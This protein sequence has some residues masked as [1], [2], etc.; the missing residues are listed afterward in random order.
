MGGKGTNA[1]ITQKVVV[2]QSHDMGEEEENESY[3]YLY[4]Q[5]IAEGE[6]L[7]EGAAGAAPNG[8]MGELDDGNGT[9]GMQQDTHQAGA[10]SGIGAL[11]N[12]DV[13]TGT[14]GA[15]THHGKP[16]YQKIPPEKY[17][18]IIHHSPRLTIIL[19][20]LET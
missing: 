16:K 3:N 18:H 13:T 17:A 11:A 9:K 6:G 5:D 15:V 14:G 19:N 8:D 2:A 1:A 12:G 7:S 20:I 4:D 10:E